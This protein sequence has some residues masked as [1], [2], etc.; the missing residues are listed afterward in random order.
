MSLTFCKSLNTNHLL[1][2]TSL[3]R[4]VSLTTKITRDESIC[5]GMQGHPLSTMPHLTPGPRI[6]CPCTRIRYEPLY[7]Q[8][9]PTVP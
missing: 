1:R 5:S 4:K 9:Q 7:P 3:Y 2:L 8:N 6:A